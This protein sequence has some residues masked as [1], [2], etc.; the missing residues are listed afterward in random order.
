MPGELGDDPHGQGEVGSGSVDEFAGVAAGRPG[1][2]LRARTD[3]GETTD[4]ADRTFRERL[5]RR[6]DTLEAERA[7]KATELDALE[8]VRDSE[9]TQDFNLIDAVPLLAD[10]AITRAPKRIQRK[11]YDA[12]QLRIQ[13]DRPD[14][15]RFR[16]RL[17]DDSARLLA[18]AVGAEPGTRAHSTATPPGAP[19]LKSTKARI[20]VRAFRP[21]PVF[22]RLPF[23][24][25]RP[26]PRGDR[27][28]A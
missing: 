25:R 19:H 10:I 5:R 28:V 16:L 15:A 2:G 8:A 18:K 3:R 6:F 11:L 21:C 20:Q 23:E 7:T 9:P 27:T 13:Y 1:D 17:I 24:G 12:L 4:P 14:Q 22:A 26:G